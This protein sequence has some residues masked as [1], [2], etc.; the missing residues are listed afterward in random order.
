MR[1]S[2]DGTSFLRRVRI[3]FTDS[4]LGEKGR[5]HAYNDTN[6]LGSDQAHYDPDLAHPAVGYKDV[7][8][9]PT[10]PAGVSERKLLT[11]I[12]LRVIP[13]LSILYLL[14]FLD[15][16][17]IANAAVFGLA[18]DLGLVGNQY[19]NALVIFFGKPLGVACP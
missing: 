1:F 12:D 15:R 9:G 2:L 6:G 3:D 8:A 13:V 10:L 7:Q 16:T 5:S 4:F 19:N 17:N 11:K 14:A 18:G